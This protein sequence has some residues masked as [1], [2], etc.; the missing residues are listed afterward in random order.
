MSIAEFDEQQQRLINII[1]EYEYIFELRKCCGYKEWINVYKTMTI[2]DLY[3]KVYHRFQLNKEEDM[4]NIYL[5]I[6]GQDGQLSGIE[7]NDTR[8]IRELIM[9]NQHHFKA[10]YPLPC[11]LVYWLY[12]DDG[13]CHSDHCANKIMNDCVIHR[14][15]IVPK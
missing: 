15:E 11:K 5:F 6:L 4:N 9:N 13:G 2:C 14:N 12:I 7:K 10:V 1:H 3:K 8:T